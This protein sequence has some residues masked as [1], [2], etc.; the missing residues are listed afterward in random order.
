LDL[1][2]HYCTETGQTEY[3]LYEA[4][5]WLYTNG[6]IEKPKVDIVKIIQKALRRVSQ[7]DFIEDENGEPV[8]HRHVY[9]EKRGDQMVMHW[10]KMEDAT[11]EKMHLSAQSRMRGTEMDILQL[12]RDLS[13]YN[14][15]F[16]P[17]DPIKMDYNFNPAVEERHLPTEYPEA[18]PDSEKDQSEEP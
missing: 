18:R 4:A 3:D 1:I 12:D 7:Q 10:F 9:K 15:H 6:F 2:D 14:H 5:A 8:R 17:G 16:N 11:R 13:Y